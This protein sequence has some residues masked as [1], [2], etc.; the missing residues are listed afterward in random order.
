MLSFLYTLILGG[1]STLLF[2]FM[3][4]RLIALHALVSWKRIWFFGFLY[5][6]VLFSWIL[7]AYP[8]DDF[9]LPKYIGLLVIFIF[10]LIVCS[11]AGSSL[12]IFIYSKRLRLVWHRMVYFIFI[13]FIFDVVKNVALS[14]LFYS[15]SAGFDVHWGFGL[16]LLSFALTPLLHLGYFFGT[17]LLAFTFIGIGLCFAKNKV[18]TVVVTSLAL[19][20]ISLLSIEPDASPSYFRSLTKGGKQVVVFSSQGKDAY[21]YRD[22]LDVIDKMSL[23]D[24]S[25][26]FFPEDSYLSEELLSSLKMFYVIHGE[27]VVSNG[28]MYNQLTLYFDGNKEVLTSKNFLIPFGERVPFFFSLLG[29]FLF[30]GDHFESLKEMREYSVTTLGGPKSITLDGYSFLVALCSDAWSK[31]SGRFFSQ[32]KEE[33]IYIIQSNRIFHGNKWFLVNLFAWHTSLSVLYDKNVIAVPRDSPLWA[34]GPSE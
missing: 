31:P 20:T 19:L 18:A 32:T 12:L 15:D 26:I 8:L 33:D 3:A 17:A 6:C 21:F 2:S 22:V 27:T 10:Y 4:Y 11:V 13:F 25:I 16:P 5:Y 30:L 28:R 1:I 9:L 34:I 7:T 24:K 29:D 14:L 23:P